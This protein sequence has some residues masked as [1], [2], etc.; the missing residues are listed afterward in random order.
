MSYKSKHLAKLIPL[1]AV[2][3]LTLAE[4]SCQNKNKDDVS[5][6]DIEQGLLTKN[7]PDINDKYGSIVSLQHVNIP[8]YNARGERIK[9]CSILTR[10]Q[11]AALFAEYNYG[12]TSL[13]R[14]YFNNSSNA[15]YIMAGAH[16]EVIDE[17]GRFIGLVINDRG[18]VIA[19]APQNMQKYI[20]EYDKILSDGYKDEKKHF[21]LVENNSDSLRYQ[22]LT[23]D[24]AELTNDS[25]V[26]D[27]VKRT[28]SVFTERQFIDSLI[29]NTRE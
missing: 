18:R 11:D 20:V 12:K 29:S 24:T 26:K 13:Q 8:I 25:V 21:R 22:S 10:G 28:E 23:E 27:S 14:A 17:K 5:T 9:D 2:T 3:L 1:T 4:T 16:R 19:I 15:V 7:V 6:N